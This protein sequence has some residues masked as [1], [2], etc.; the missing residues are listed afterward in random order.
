LPG[1]D[2]RPLVTLNGQADFAEVFFNDVR[3]PADALLGPENGGWR[4]ATTTL[5]YERAGAARLYTEMQE[6]LAELVRDLADVRNDNRPAL[7][8]PTTLRRIGEIAVRVKYLEMLCKRSISAI[9][10]G[11]DAFG[12]AS[13]AKTIWG[14]V[15][16]Q[17]GA[18]GFDLLGSHPDGGQWAD[19]RLTSRSLTI[20]G[21]TTQINKNITAQRVL[22]LPRS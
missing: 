8:D 5:S 14:E 19:Y 4:I 7:E 11:G 10:Y 13:L 9:L 18:L 22:G 6:R 17:I 3:V 20:A 12:S 21:G 16:Q 2:V 1:I 15:G